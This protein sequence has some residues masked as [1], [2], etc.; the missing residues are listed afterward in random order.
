MNL[1]QSDLVK[2]QDHKSRLESLIGEVYNEVFNEQ[3]F[4]NRI[5]DKFLARFTSEEWEFALVIGLQ[6]LFPFYHIERVGGKDEKHH[7]TDILIKLP[8][9]SADYEYAIAIQ[10]KDYSGVVGD[11]V[12]DQINKAEWWETENLKLIDK[13][14][15]VTK[16]EKDA[17]VSLTNNS[18]NVKIL[19][20][21]EL[22]ELLSRIAKNMTG[23]K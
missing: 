23:L 8:S 13:W 6:E 20:A 18:N 16:A 2:R 22:K 5:Y 17:N 19:F 7:G 11:N 15:I 14:I 3:E 10:V 9:L 21:S 4:T 12:I 1:D